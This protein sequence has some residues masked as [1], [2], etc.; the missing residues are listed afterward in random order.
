MSRRW[1]S[2]ERARRKTTDGK[3]WEFEQTGSG[4]VVGPRWEL[5]AGSSVATGIESPFL[6]GYQEG[7]F[8]YLMIAADKV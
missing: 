6:T 1:P 7:S 4:W 8:Q 2:V 5:R 3:R